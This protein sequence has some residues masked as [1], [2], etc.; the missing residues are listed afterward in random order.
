MVK[1]QVE[2]SEYYRVRMLGN[3]SGI[4]SEE[5]LPSYPVWK[6]GAFT[7]AMV[8]SSEPTDLVCTLWLWTQFRVFLMW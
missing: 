3:A 7:T 2:L 6:G 8:I 5:N 4:P 1:I